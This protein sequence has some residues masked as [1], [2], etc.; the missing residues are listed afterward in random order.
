MPLVRPG[1]R[2][3]RN[4]A[5]RVYPEYTPGIRAIDIE[6]ARFGAVAEDSLRHRPWSFVR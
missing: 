3:S 6:G 1:R 4:N 2:R 5:T